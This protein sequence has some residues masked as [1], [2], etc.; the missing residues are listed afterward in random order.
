MEISFIGWVHTILGTAAILV[1][2]YIIVS[3]G[4][5]TSNNLIGKFYIIA[6]L[7]IGRAHV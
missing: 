3:K 4:Y 5:I 2:I 6:T 7:K 1:S